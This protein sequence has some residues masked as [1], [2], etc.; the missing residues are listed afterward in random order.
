M[1]GKNYPL[2]KNKNR[3]EVAKNW[4]QYPNLNIVAVAEISLFQA[5][6]SL[7]GYDSFD[8]DKLK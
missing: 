8:I 2:H 6:N 1:I 7:K 3:G 4:G 5:I